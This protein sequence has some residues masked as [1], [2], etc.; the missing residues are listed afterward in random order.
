MRRKAKIILLKSMPLEFHFQKVLKEAFEVYC[1][2]SGEDPSLRGFAKHLGINSGTLFL[3][4][5]GQ[6]SLNTVNAKKVADRLALNP[7]QRKAFLQSIAEYKGRKLQ[8]D[9]NGPK[10]ESLELSAKDFLEILSEPKY[11]RFLQLLRSENFNP[12][13]DWIAAKLSSTSQEI[14]LLIAKLEQMQIIQRTESNSWICRYGSIELSHSLNGPETLA[15]RAKELEL[16]EQTPEKI[17]QA[18][19]ELSACILAVDP[20]QINT[21]KELMERMKEELKLLSTPTGEQNT[22]LFSV[23]LHSLT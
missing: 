11:L 15:I 9:D 8:D 2:N 18:L 16:I 22:Y 3:I 1:K 19:H 10:V 21:V 17:Q 20:S 5:K 13:L 23:H 7:L 4:F 14:E 12:A 6:R